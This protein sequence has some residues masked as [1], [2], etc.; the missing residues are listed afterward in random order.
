MAND[1]AA[2]FEA[3]R[4]MLKKYSRGMIT[5]TDTPTDFTVVSRGIGP[6][7]RPMW[8]GAV[9]L[10]KSAVTFH[11]MPLYFNP[12]LQ[13]AVPAE[14]LRRQ[15]GKTCFNFQRTD[16]ELFS[17]LDELTKRG[18]E[19]WERHGPIPQ[20]RFAA[21]LRAGGADPESLAKVRKAKGKAAAQKRAATIKKKKSSPTIKRSGKK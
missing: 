21:A 8:F 13:A 12:T 17:Q 7:K 3:L 9:Q 11:L 19:Q 15:Q 20:E 4:S 16:Q 6:N 2:A 18:R 1:F 10:K 14:L 5:Q